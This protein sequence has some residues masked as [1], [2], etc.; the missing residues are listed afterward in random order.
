MSLTW[1]G[2]R[3]SRRWAAG[4]VAVVGA[5]AGAGSTPATGSGSGACCASS[6]TDGGGVDGG[7]SLSI[8]GV[9]G[10]TAGFE[11][12]ACGATAGLNV[13]SDVVISI[14]LGWYEAQL[15]DGERP[16]GVNEREQGALVAGLEA[17]LLGRAQALLRELEVG[18]VMQRFARPVEASLQPRGERAEGRGAARLGLDDPEGGLEQPASLGWALGQVVGA[19]QSLGLLAR[20]PVALYR[21]GHGLLVLGAERAQRMSQRHAESALV[22]LALQ[23]LAQLLGQREPL[24]DP[25][26]LSPAGMGDGLGPQL[27]LVPQRPDHPGFVHR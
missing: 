22:D 9:N 19:E 23:R 21:A 1:R 15:L 5:G 27:L 4:A 7:G 26:R 25:A 13:W 8:F 2:L 18:Q 24:L 10:S 20:E 11:A 12:G 17:A 6:A 14:L 3:S 16:G